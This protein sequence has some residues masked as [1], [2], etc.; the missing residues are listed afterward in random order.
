MWKFSANERIQ[1]L[2]VDRR[3]SEGA[4]SWNATTHP[5]TSTKSASKAREGRCGVTFYAV[6]TCGIPVAK[7]TIRN[8]GCGL[9]KMQFE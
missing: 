7:R 2:I 4:Q 5:L 6:D 8:F 3:L 1:A 9:R